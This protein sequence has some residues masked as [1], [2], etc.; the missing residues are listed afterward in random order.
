MKNWA[1]VLVFFFIMSCSGTIDKPKNLISK[2]VMAEI[3]ADIALSEQAIFIYPDKNLESG[4]LFVLQQHKVKAEDFV[5][6]Y[7]YYLVSKKLKNIVDD[8]KTIILEKD[9]KAEKYIQ[10]KLKAEQKQLEKLPE[11]EKNFVR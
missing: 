9:P 8:A 4:T 5:E 1:F 6:S 11:L 3:L 7:K 10:D 2:N